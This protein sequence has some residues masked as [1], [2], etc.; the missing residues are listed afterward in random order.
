MAVESESIP[1][2][3]AVVLRARGHSPHF[4]ES[5]QVKYLQVGQKLVPLHET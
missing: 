1:A 4:P 5:H 3:G 2:V